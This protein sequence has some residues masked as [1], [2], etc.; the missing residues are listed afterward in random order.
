[1]RIRAHK[2]FRLVEVSY[3]FGSFSELVPGRKQRMISDRASCQVNP[4]DVIENIWEWDGV[5]IKDIEGSPPKHSLLNS[6]G[7]GRYLMENPNCP[8]EIRGLLTI[9]ELFPF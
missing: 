8:I 1:M 4:G 3:F 7:D 5:W 2:R 9:E 6:M